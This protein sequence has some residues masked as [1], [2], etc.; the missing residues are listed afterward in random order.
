MAQVV[1]GIS[2]KR[3]SGKDTSADFLLKHLENLGISVV[4]GAFADQLKKEYCEASSV[5]FDELAK[6]YKLKSLHRPGIIKMGNDQKA[7]HGEDIWIRKLL[8][9]PEIKDYQVLIVSD[10]RYPNEAKSIRKHSKKSILFRINIDLKL[11]ELRG[12]SWNEDIDKNHS[13]TSLDSYP[14]FDLILNN[15][16]NTQD[17]GLVILEKLIPKIVECID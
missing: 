1:V 3:G 4:K 6:N 10:L 5:N 15:N 12:I 14:N 16:V 17:L 9:N 11:R 8:K 13:E 2:G 7:I